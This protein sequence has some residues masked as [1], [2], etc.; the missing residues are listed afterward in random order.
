MPL[1][2]RLPKGR[3]QLSPGQLLFLQ[4]AEWPSPDTAYGHENDPGARYM[5]SMRHCWLTSPWRTG[6]MPD[7][8][9]TAAELWEQYGEQITRQWIAAHPGSRPAG[10][11]RFSAPVSPESDDDQLAYLQ[12]HHL[13]TP[14]EIQALRRG[15]SGG[16][17]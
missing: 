3:D 12:K 16:G 4:G 11:W 17:R 14:A 9:A 1:K 10:W 2:R 13:L 15:D 8:S 6:A 5:E 7:D